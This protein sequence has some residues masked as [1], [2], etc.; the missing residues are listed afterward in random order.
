MQDNRSPKLKPRT[1]LIDKPVESAQLK[2]ELVNFK[3][4]QQKLLKLKHKEI[5]EKRIEHVFRTI[6]ILT[7]RTAIFITPIGISED[8]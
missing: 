8:M 3:L 4:N 6:S 2:K 1:L 7:V 5:R